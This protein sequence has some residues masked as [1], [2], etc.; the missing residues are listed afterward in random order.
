MNLSLKELK[1]RTEAERQKNVI[2]VRAR[3]LLVEV[4]GG[5]RRL[6]GVGKREESIRWE[7]D[8]AGVNAA[9]LNIVLSSRKPCKC[10]LA[11]II[12]GLSP[13]HKNRR[14][15]CAILSTRTSR[16]GRSFTPWHKPSRLAQ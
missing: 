3:H 9:S 10:A 2:A 5:E 1:E 11:H 6:S 16:R 14:S 7:T 8:T 4:S 12:F 15:L 13:P